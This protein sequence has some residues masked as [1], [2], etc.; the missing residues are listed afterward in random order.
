[1]KTEFVH[2]LRRALGGVLGWGFSLGLLGV[3]IM[4][5]FNTIKD[6]GDMLMALIDQYPRELMAFFGGAEALDLFTPAGYLTIE[7]FSYMPLVLGIFGVLAGSSM[8][9]GDEEN[10]LLDLVMAYP[11][12]RTGLY[13]GRLLGFA[14]TLATILILTWVAFA[15]GI[16]ATGMEVT[17]LALTYPF[18]SLYAV[19]FLFGSFTVFLSMVVPSRSMAAMLG[20]MAMVGSYF[21]QALSGITEDLKNVARFLPLHYYQSGYAIEGL[22]V[23]WLAGLLG[24]GA[25][26][27]VLGWL[28]FMRRD[29]RVSGE[30][31]WQFHFFRGKSA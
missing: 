27:S 18:L 21:V 15:V 12:S 13:F 7:Y 25:V 19:V 1:M 16:G 11:V 28:L 3:F 31:S 23:E 20:G 14:T 29:I 9:A 17:A 5:F 2:H 6:Q 30:G 24:A 26:F 22:N 10:G 8:L 4:A